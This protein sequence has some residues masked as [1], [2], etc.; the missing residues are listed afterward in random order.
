MDKKVKL[1][2]AEW[3]LPVDGPYGCKIAAEIGFEGIQLDVG[4]YERNFPKTKK[5][6]LQK[7]GNSQ[8]D[9]SYFRSKKN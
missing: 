1:G 4:S 3:A 8:K 2:I 5:I 7:H 9:L 6:V